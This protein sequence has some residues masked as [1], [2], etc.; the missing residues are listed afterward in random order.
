MLSLSSLS[1]NTNYEIGSILPKFS[2]NLKF[3]FASYIYL[4]YLGI[5]KCNLYPNYEIKLTS[6]GKTVLNFLESRN[7]RKHECSVINLESFKK[8]R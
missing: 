5:I 6:L 8:S 7:N 1:E 3:F 2:N 4:Q